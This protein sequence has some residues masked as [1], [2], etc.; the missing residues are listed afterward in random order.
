MPV[1]TSL[2]DVRLLGFTAAVGI[3][4]GV[5]FGLA[6][7]IHMTRTNV[8]HALKESGARGSGGVSVGRMRGA[9]VVAEMSLAVVLLVGALL[10]IR[11][12]AGLRAIDPGFDPA[13]VLTM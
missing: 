11:T 7:A 13:N 10:L 3:L 1:V 12:F 8:M 5:L 9:F 2:L 4:T 6:P